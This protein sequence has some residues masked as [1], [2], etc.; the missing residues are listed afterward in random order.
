MCSITEHNRK[1]PTYYYDARIDGDR[2]IINNT[3]TAALKSLGATLNFID[4]WLK[5]FQHNYQEILE[6]YHDAMI[7]LFKHI[8]TMKSKPLSQDKMHQFLLKYIGGSW[9]M[10]K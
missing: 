9:Y 1:Q 5:Y 3:T 8:P 6:M 7:E 10:E 4:F 2:A